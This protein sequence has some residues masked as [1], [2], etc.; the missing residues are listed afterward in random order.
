MKLNVTGYASFNAMNKQNFTVM[1]TKFDLIILFLL[2]D[3][4]TLTNIILKTGYFQISSHSLR[5]K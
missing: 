4:F 5:N 1:E 3:N 2:I